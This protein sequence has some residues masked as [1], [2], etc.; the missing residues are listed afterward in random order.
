MATYLAR[1]AKLVGQLE[2]MVKLLDSPVDQKTFASKVSQWFDE[3]IKIL[4]EH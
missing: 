2:A 4:N 1:E 3:A